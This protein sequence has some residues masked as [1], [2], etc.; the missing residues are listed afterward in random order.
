MKRHPGGGTQGRTQG[1]RAWLHY[2]GKKQGRGTPVWTRRELEA[3]G[4]RADEEMG[5]GCADHPPH[6]DTPSAAKAYRAQAAGKELG[7][8][9]LLYIN[10]LETE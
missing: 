5:D 9:S 10:S 7:R 6:G 2:T 3:K 1:S 4:I 8:A